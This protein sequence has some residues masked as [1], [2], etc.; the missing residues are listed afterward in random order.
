MSLKQDVVAAFNVYSVWCCKRRSCFRSVGSSSLSWQITDRC[1][2][3]KSAPHI[4]AL[5]FLWAYTAMPRVVGPHPQITSS[6]PFPR[7][8]YLQSHSSAWCYHD[9]K[10]HVWWRTRFEVPQK[11]IP[12]FMWLNVVKIVAHYCY[13]GALHSTCGLTSVYRDFN[14]TQF[15]WYPDMSP[16]Q[17]AAGSNQWLVG[18]DVMHHTVGLGYICTPDLVFWESVF[19]GSCSPSDQPAEQSL[20]LNETL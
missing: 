17:N 8:D 18:F 2:P 15:A 14:V 5:S 1:C 4:Y 10:A 19:R 20:P 12:N 3:W 16:L 13:H 6:L 11:R 9:L 7:H